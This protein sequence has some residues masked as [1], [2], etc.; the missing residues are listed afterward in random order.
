VEH[1]VRFTQVGQEVILR[2]RTLHSVL[3]SSTGDAPRFVI[4]FGFPRGRPED[5]HRIAQLAAMVATSA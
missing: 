4:W 5:D 2:A 3:T 1:A